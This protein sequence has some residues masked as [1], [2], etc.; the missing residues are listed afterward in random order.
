MILVVLA[1]GRGEDSSL[2]YKIR[3][4]AVSMRHAPDA[5][6][7]RDGGVEEDGSICSGAS[8]WQEVEEGVETGLFA[9]WQ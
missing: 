6:N 4:E 3:P 1:I 2:P 8:S 5:Y 9:M 7:L